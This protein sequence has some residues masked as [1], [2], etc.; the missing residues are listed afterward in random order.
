M[1][2]KSRHEGGSRPAKDTEAV[3]GRLHSAAI[4][5]LRRLRQSDKASGVSAARLSALSVLVFGGGRTIGQLADVEQV[6]PPTMTR[7]VQALE[8]EGYIRRA[9]DPDDRRAVRLF[10]TA[11]AQRLLER[12]RKSRIDALMQ[13]IRPLNAADVKRLGRAADLIEQIVTTR[14]M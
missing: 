5:L 12:S 13:L 4:H 9:P 3:A 14:T 6:R 11:K 2:G 8:A 10:A 7:L 1:T